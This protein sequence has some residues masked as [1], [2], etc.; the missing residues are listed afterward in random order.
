LRI[1]PFDHPGDLPPDAKA[2]FDD[3]HTGR[4]FRS[5]EWIGQTTPAGLQPGDRLRLYLVQGDDGSAQALLPAVY[6]R[7]YA[8][9]PDARV[10]HFLQRDEL[11]YEPIGPAT[12]PAPVVAALGAWLRDNPKAIDVLRV[13]PLDPAQP[14]TGHVLAALRDSGYWPQLYRHAQSRYADVAGM[15]FAD[16]L[17]QRPRALRESLDLNTRLLMQ[18]GRGEFHFPCTPELVSDAW[19]SVRY[20][21]DRAPEEDV[22]D[23]LDYIRAVLE[24][25]ASFDALR[26]GIFSLDGAPVAIQLWVVTQRVARCLRIWGAQGQRVFPIDD[27]LTQ[28][29]TLCLIDGDQVEELEFGDV[30]EAFA[31]DW[32][33]LARDRLGLAAFNRRTARG[34][35]GAVRHIALPRLLG[36]PRRAWRRLFG[37]R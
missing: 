10:L 25:A 14:F 3:A 36:A 24:T 34:L 6:S 4:L 26:L 30:S 20:V 27:V 18:G 16:Y 11:P 13:S 1:Q 29:V 5:F 37:G 21:I 9:H 15:R 28:L 2:L 17:A 19:D 7:L 12:D 32:A 31:A 33:P 8:S 35:H 23:S 22:P